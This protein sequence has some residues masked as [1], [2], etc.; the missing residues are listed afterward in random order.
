MANCFAPEFT[1]IGAGEEQYIAEREAAV[2][3]FRQFQ[4]AIPTCRIWDE[5]YDVIEP[6]P[7]IYVV[8]GRMWIAT[9]PGVEMYL[10]VH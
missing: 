3:L 4:G 5:R 10:K 1:W 2:E 7:G 9:D 6:S 8:S